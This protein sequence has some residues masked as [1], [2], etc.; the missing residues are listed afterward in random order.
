MAEEGGH[1]SGIV[2]QREVTF[3]MHL[4]RVTRRL[5][6]K[7]HRVRENDNMTVSQPLP[8]LWNRHR[9]ITYPSYRFV[10]LA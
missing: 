6:R 4:H 8:P 10:S 1:I 9:E 7:A 5:Y 3:F 2:G